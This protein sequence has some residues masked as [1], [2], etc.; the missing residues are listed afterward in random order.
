MAGPWTPPDPLVDTQQPNAA[1]VL[2]RPVIVPGPKPVSPTFIPGTHQTY[3]PKTG[4]AL[5]IPNVKPEPPADKTTYRPMTV[6]EK[7]AQNLSPEAPWLMGSNGDFKLPDGYKPEADASKT[8][9]AKQEAIDS[10]D[11]LIQGV[12]KARS[13][14]NDANNPILNTATGLGYQI[15]KHVPSTDAAKLDAVI[16]QEIRGNIFLK[17]LGDL[18]AAN[19]SPNGGTGIGRIMQAEIPLITGAIGT[20]QPGQLGHQE[21]LNSL[22]QI[23]RSAGRSKAMLNGENP[24]DPAIQKKYGIPPLPQYPNGGLPGASPPN[25][26]SSPPSGPPAAPNGGGITPSNPLPPLTGLDPESVSNGD[27]KIVVNP[28]LAAIAGQLTTYLNADPKKV[29]NAMIVGFMQKHGVDPSSTNLIPLL[30]MRSSGKYKGFTVDPR[31]TVPLTGVAKAAA[32]VSASAPAAAILHSADAVTAGNLDKI[33]PNGEATDRALG[34]TSM[35]HPAAS[36]AGDVAGGSTAAM[37]LEALGGAAGVG[38]GLLR[39]LAADSAYGG[40]AGAK[41][42]HPIEGLLLGA[43]GNLGG[44]A[45]G[46]AATAALSGVTDPA[47]GYVAREAPG[48]MTVGQVVGQSGLPGKIVK[49]IEDRAAGLPIVGDAIKARHLEGL[50]KMNAS[51]FDRALEPIGQKAEGRFGEEAVQHAQDKVSAAFH[52]ALNGKAATADLP[53]VTQAAAAKRQIRDL[54]PSVAKDVENHVDTIVKDYFDPGTLSI[55][56][57]NMQLLLRDVHQFKRVSTLED[58]VLRAKNTSKDGNAVFT[59]AQLGMADRANTIRYGGKHG[60]AAGKGEFHDFQRNM[61]EVLPNKV[62]DSGTAGRVAL[63]AAPAALSGAGAGVGAVGGDAQGGAET[64]LTLGA[65]LAAA[66]SRTGQRALTSAVLKRPSAAKAAG[67]AIQ[68]IV[69]AL[70]H[71]AGTTAAVRSGR[72]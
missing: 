3:D 62:P 47:I 32:K 19:D 55:S 5:D 42:G 33:I 7:S 27:S 18:K 15:L 36:L 45:V 56:G 60:A 9:V 58:A 6:A 24:D 41:S 71:A 8:A 48:A 50:Q 11:A 30:Q 52:T 37:G 2:G 43:G 26:G 61:Q 53:F 65:L 10:A 68:K 72:D 16:N 44:R 31:S 21:T 14:I 35:M 13:F 28:Q 57:D 17:R 54:P 1:T 25:G 40:A 34:A 49:G 46:K 67:A 29:T 22:D 38:P 69:P 70:G 4:T 20:L 23:E 59:P 66:Y 64:G 39:A 51:A 12:H 63:L